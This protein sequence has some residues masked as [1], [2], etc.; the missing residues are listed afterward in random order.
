MRRVVLVHGIDDSGSVFGHLESDL[1]RAGFSVVCVDL[2]PSDGRA[3][4]ETSAEQLRKAVDCSLSPGE[5]YSMVAF[6]MGGLIARHYLQ[7]LGGCDRVDAL[8]TISCPHHGTLC[9][10]LRRGRGVS[11][12][13]PGSPFLRALAATQQ[14]LAGI[15]LTSCWTPFDLAIVP[16]R[17]SFW[18]LAR[19][20][21]FPVPLHPWML[22]SRQVRRDVVNSLLAALRSCSPGP[23]P[24][25]ACRVTGSGRG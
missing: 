4:L 1:R 17:S 24:L 19:N 20:K 12:I 5:R 25:A 21:T 8:Y 18:M 6:S 14:R 22:K 7:F 23:Y 11:Q 3:E 9:A 13:R 15:S 16:A 10:Y 2:Q